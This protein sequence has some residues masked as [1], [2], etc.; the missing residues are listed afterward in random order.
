MLLGSTTVTGG[1]AVD[2]TV[3]VAVGCEEGAGVKDPDGVAEAVTDLVTLRVGVTERPSLTTRFRAGVV[4]STP[5]TK[6]TA[7]VMTRGS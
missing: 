3:T 5:T 7:A 1:A 6:K 2:V 4:M